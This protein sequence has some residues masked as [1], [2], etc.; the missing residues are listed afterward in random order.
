MRYQISNFEYLKL[1]LSEL[2]DDFSKHWSEYPC[3]EWPFQKNS[4]GY[5][6]V[7]VYPK[8]TGAHRV[9]LNLVSSVPASMLVCHHCD[10]RM[11]F[12][13][14]HLF[15]GTHKENTHDMLRKGRGNFP[16]MQGERH[17]KAKLTEHM[18][19]QIRERHARGGCT[20]ESIAEELSMDA[21]TIG[22]AIKRVTWRLVI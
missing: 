6:I 5:G 22:D 11:C 17:H 2:D 9:A 8:C 16:G 15:V 1:R 20:Y 13:P 19:R 12:R 7:F 4:N 18:V 14:I 3:M 10:N 21:S